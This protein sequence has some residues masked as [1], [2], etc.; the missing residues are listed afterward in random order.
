MIVMVELL[1][2]EDGSARLRPV[3]VL[4]LL[5]LGSITAGAA[6]LGLAIGVF[7]VA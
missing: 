2:V 5:L 7:L 4:A 3:T 1:R 6:Q